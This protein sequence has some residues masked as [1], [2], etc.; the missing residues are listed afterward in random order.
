MFPGSFVELLGLRL[1]YPELTVSLPKTDPQRSHNT[2]R[3]PCGASSSLQRATCERQSVPESVEANYLPTN[4]VLPQ[5]RA[6]LIL[7]AA[8]ADS[9]TLKISELC[10][11]A[12]QTH[13]YSIIELPV[14]IHDICHARGTRP[15]HVLRYTSR[16]R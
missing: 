14:L 15:N 11:G 5:M 12:V 7:N 1:R 2:P 13:D 9:C 16:N 4:E 10:V 8:F 3:S 6:R